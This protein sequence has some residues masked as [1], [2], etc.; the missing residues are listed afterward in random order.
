MDNEPETYR[1]QDQRP[2]EQRIKGESVMKEFLNSLD[3]MPLLVK[4]ILAIPA[5]D[6]VWNIYRIVSA[7]YKKDMVALIV[8]IVLL[9]IPITWIFDIVMVLL[10]GSV[11]KMA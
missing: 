9:F 11:W 8:S 2:T 5:L 10:T 4:L 3:S 7:V 6:I 1:T